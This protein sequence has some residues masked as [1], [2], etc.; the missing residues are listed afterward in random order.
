MFLNAISCKAFCFIDDTLTHSPT[1]FMHSTQ[2]N[3]SHPPSTSAQNVHN[4]CF[5]P[6]F[7]SIIFLL[8]N[9][10][11]SSII[12]SVQE[13]SVFSTRNL[14]PDIVNQIR[15]EKINKKNNWKFRSENP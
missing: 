5:I 4:A 9:L 1:Y 11:F 7:K 14:V 6:S 8:H 3:P 12:K 2:T 13:Y 10:S 15:N